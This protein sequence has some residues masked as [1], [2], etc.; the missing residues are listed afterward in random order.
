MEL[1]LSLRGENPYS[2]TAIHTGQI[3]DEDE[4]WIGQYYIVTQIAFMHRWSCCTIPS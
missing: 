3:G 1:Y 4:D 2:L